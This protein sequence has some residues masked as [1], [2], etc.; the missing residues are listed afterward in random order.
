MN[1]RARR[2]PPCGRCSSRYLRA[3]KSQWCL[4]VNVILAYWS[5]INEAEVVYM[6]RLDLLQVV[7]FLPRVLGIEAST[8]HCGLPIWKAI[9]A[10]GTVSKDECTCVTSDP[11]LSKRP[12][13][14]QS[15]IADKLDSETSEA[16][17]LFNISSK[18]TLRAYQDY[19]YAFGSIFAAFPG[20]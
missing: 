20:L 14:S 17:I 16:P 9:R 11:T 10:W 13:F 6:I 8:S 18:R 5:D 7:W 12:D 3:N 2:K 15:S 4:M 19:S 1:S